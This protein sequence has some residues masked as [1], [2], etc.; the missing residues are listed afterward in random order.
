M[1]DEHVFTVSGAAAAP[2]SQITLAEAGFLERTHLQEWVIANP[3]MLGQD[4]MVVTDEFDQWRSWAGGKERDRID[5]LGLDRNGRLVVVELKRDA[6]PD[7]VE[8]QA[9]KYAAMTSRFTAETLAVHHAKYRTGRGEPTTADQALEAL[10]A[11]TEY[12][13]LPENLAR[14]GIVLLASSFPPVVTATT[15]WLTEMS[16]DITLMQLQAYRADEKIVVTVSQL[17]PVRDVEEFTVA[18]VRSAKSSSE[19]A[20]LLPEV[21]WTAEDLLRLRD[22]ANAT[23]LAALDLCA[24]QPGEWIP[25][26]QL[27]LRAGREHAQARSDLA[28]LTM[29]VKSGFGRRNWPFEAGWGKSGEK[30]SCYRLSDDL[31]AVWAGVAAAPADSDSASGNGASE[32]S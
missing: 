10:N 17:Y 11:H 2:A 32:P 6:A 5:V 15:V 1:A 19:E 9:I 7:T 13:L 29:A 27:E 26:R 21:P 22:I 4:V 20:D 23:V 16:L 31:A 8:M 3:Q 30:Q 14:P 18:P 24:E 25:L 12:N 28:Q